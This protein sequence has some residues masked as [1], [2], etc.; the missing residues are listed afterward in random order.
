MQAI[1]PE[2][3]EAYIDRLE[4]ILERKWC[5]TQLAEYK[6]FVENHSPVGLWS[7]RFPTVSPIVPLLFQYHNPEYRRKQ[8]APLG[9]WYGDPIH[10]LKQLAGQVFLFEEY[11]S[12]LPNNI[13]VSNIKYRLRTADKFDGFLFELMVA[14]DSKLNRYKNH[15]VEPLF[16]D[17]RTEEGGADILL[18][19]E[20]ERLA[21][22]CKSRSPFAALNMSFD[23]FQYIFGC[24]YRLVQDSGHSYRLTLD[25]SNR[26]QTSDAGK[27]INFLTSTVKSGL[28]VPK[29]SIDSSYQI[30]LARLNILINGIT[31]SEINRLLHK[32]PANL[33]CGIGGLNPGQGDATVFNRIAVFSVSARQAESLET[34]IIKIIRRAA[35]EANVDSP[36]ILAIHF[37]GHI[38]VEDYLRHASNR[39]RLRRKVD[40]VL[41]SF[42]SIKYVN[43]STN[44]QEY[45]TLLGGE[46]LVQTQYLEITNHFYSE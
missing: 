26:L 20:R 28:N 6:E 43:V 23:I 12:S 40:T 8:E 9:Y 11:W 34:S 1:D 14:T 19:K 2:T 44:R 42:P 27:I 39:N 21:I 32:D 30:E 17:P 36:L 31:E 41:K 10:T 5:E 37:Y 29:H 38:K 18:R 35:S 22:Q 25:L 4:D 24:F 13:G 16:F 15:D 7:H 46:Q 3:S 45:V 33:F